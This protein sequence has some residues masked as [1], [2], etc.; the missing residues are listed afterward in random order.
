MTLAQ[1][2]INSY[3]QLSEGYLSN[4][5]KQVLAFIAE[6]PFCTDRDI[7]AGLKMS[8]NQITGR[9]HELHK[10][11]IIKYAGNR[12]DIDTNRRVSTWVMS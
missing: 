12:L 1:T 8:I 5:Q 9:R 4:R 7:A 10:N 11:G 2:S 6:N 3:G